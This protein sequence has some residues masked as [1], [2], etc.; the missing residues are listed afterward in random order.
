[1]LTQREFRRGKIEESDLSENLFAEGKNSPKSNVMEKETASLV[2][3]VH[4][5]KVMSTPFQKGKEGL[6]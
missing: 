2:K 4:I 6:S 5:K 3:V 1:M